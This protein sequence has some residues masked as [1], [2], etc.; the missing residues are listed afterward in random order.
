MSEGWQWL[1]G[2]TEHVGRLLTVVA[3]V[4]GLPAGLALVALGWWAVVVGA[5]LLVLLV[6][7]E[8]AFR[9]WHAIDRDLNRDFPHH[10]LKVDPAWSAEIPVEP[11]YTPRVLFLPITFTN[12]EPARRC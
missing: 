9:V 2:V 1:G 4:V 7:A 8:G 10:A 5:A 11:Q 6:F 3:L 12:R